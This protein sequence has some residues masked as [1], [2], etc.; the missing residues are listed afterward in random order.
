[1]QAG[2]GPLANYAIVGDAP[3]GGWTPYTEVIA[4][5]YV[6]NNRQASEMK[7]RGMLSNTRSY[8]TGGILLDGVMNITPTNAINYG[9]TSTYNTPKNKASSSA[10]ASAVSVAAIAPVVEAIAAPI[11]MGVS[12]Q[13]SQ[14]S[15][16]MQATFTQVRQESKKTNDLLSAILA[17][18]ASDN[19]IASAFVT[20][21]GKYS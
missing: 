5:G 9:A 20:A 1:M 12:Q 6:Y 15:L 14:Q 16:Q 2:G 8:A 10:V 17:K 13:V 18:V 11:V 3:G 21:Q 7:R 19:G 4:G